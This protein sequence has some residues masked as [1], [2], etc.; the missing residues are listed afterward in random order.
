MIESYV[1]SELFHAVVLLELTNITMIIASHQSTLSSTKTINSVMTVR[2]YSIQ[3]REMG[4]QSKATFWPPKIP[5]TDMTP[6][7]LN[8]ALPTMVPIPKSLL[9][10]KVPIMFVKSSGA[11]VPE[12]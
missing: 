6:K 5:Q 12:K 2:P 4:Y 7:M 9:V 8:T 10:T 3:S 11:L 1:I